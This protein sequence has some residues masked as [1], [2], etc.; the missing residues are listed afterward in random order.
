MDEKS[1]VFICQ[2]C[3]TEYE[4]NWHSVRVYKRDGETE[5]FMRCTKDGGIAYPKDDSSSQIIG[6]LTVGEYIIP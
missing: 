6:E 4:Y 2:S 5:H 1:N 3:E